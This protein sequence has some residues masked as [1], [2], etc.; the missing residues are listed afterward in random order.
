MV[1]ISTDFKKYPPTVTRPGLYTIQQVKRHQTRYGPTLILTLSNS[2]GEKFSLFVSCPEEISDKSLLARLS[3]AFGKDTEAWLS[4]KI[5]L[6]LDR[7]GRRR[8][9][10]IVAKPKRAQQ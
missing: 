9:D 5:D 4:K 2:M 1:E 10:P 3:R 7:N 6:A 8:I